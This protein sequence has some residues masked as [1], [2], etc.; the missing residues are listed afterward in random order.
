MVPAV[1][2]V[3][4]MQTQTWP[5]VGTYG[6]CPDLTTPKVVRMYVDWVVADAPASQVGARPN[7][8]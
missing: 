7:A 2:M 5:C 6:R 8:S 3:L 1:P 4:D